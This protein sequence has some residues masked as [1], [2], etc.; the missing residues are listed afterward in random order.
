MGHYVLCPVL[1]QYFVCSIARNARNCYVLVTFCV[2]QSHSGLGLS[3][4]ECICICIGPLTH[5]H[6]HIHT[7]TYAHTYTHNLQQTHTHMHIH[8][9]THARTVCAALVSHNRSSCRHFVC[10]RFAR[11]VP[12]LTM[13]SFG[14]SMTAFV[15]VEVARIGLDSISYAK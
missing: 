5:T 12:Q 15:R 9:Q 7:Y 11:S 8:I 13:S 2:G 14:R 10:A 6:M 3:R 1:F 4:F